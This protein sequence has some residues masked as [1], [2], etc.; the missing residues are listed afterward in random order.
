MHHQDHPFKAGDRVEFTQP[1]GVVRTGTVTAYPAV[2]ED[3]ELGVEYADAGRVR[4]RYATD[5]TWYFCSPKLARVRHLI[6]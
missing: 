6:G 5:A 2:L 4:V 1:S 3:E